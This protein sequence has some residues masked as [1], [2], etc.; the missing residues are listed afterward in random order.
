MQDLAQVVVLGLIAAG[1]YALFAI[2][3]V[4]VYR[5]TRVLTF[6][7]GEVGTAALYVAA[8]L[9]SDHGAPWFVGA[10]AAVLVATLLGA[11]FEFFLVRRSV[12]ADPVVTSILTVGLALTLLA[13]ELKLYGASPETLDGPVSGGLTVAGVVVSW[14][15]VSA[16]VVAAALGFGLQSVLRRTDFG[17]GILAA[18]EDPSAARLVGVPLT[19]VRLVLW[20]GSFGLAAVAALLVEPTVGVITPGYASTLYLGGLAAAVVGRLD[21]LPAAVGGAVLIGLAESAATRYLRHW[22]VPGMSYLVVLAVLLVTLLTRA[23]LPELK[24][25]LSSAR[26]PVEATA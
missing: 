24:R 22:D 12:D 13:V 2:G 26:R 7:G 21:S 10:V 5:G 18:A 25:L 9:V 3:I 11:A 19:K 17:L 6:A 1:I 15:Q 20:A 4:L 23:Y 16:L 8:F 14:T